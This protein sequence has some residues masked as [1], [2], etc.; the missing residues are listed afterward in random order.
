MKTFAIANG[1]LVIGQGGYATVTGLPKVRQDLSIA[2]REPLGCDRFHPGWGSALLSYIGR[3]LSMEISALVEA[4]VF[5][6]VRNYMAIKANEMQREYLRGSKSNYSSDE[7]VT[8]IQ[9]VKVTWSMDR[10]YVQVSLI[11][12]GASSVT[13][14]SS[15]SA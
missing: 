12:A 15:V 6:L 5:R 13:L 4:E 1:D 7:I 9:D 10:L 3:P 2:M 8:N 11:T 14:V